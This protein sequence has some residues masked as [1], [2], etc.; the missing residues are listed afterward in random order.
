[1]GW[2]EENANMTTLKADFNGFIIRPPCLK[3]KLVASQTRAN[4]MHS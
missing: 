2:F 3:K 1:M 4:S